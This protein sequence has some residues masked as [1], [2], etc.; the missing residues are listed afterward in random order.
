[1]KGSTYKRCCKTLKVFSKSFK[2]CCTLLDYVAKSRQLS[3]IIVIIVL[4][5]MEN[6]PCQVIP[7][8]LVHHGGIK[9]GVQFSA[10]QL[11]YRAG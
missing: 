7:E 4:R 1:M 11:P 8:R 10:R 3:Q 6:L 9:A 2:R 5:I